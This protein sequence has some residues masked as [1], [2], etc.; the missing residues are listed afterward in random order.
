MYT[1]MLCTKSPKRFKYADSFEG[2]LFDWAGSVEPLPESDF[3]DPLERRPFW[4]AEEST[5]DTCTVD[6]WTWEWEWEWEWPEDPSSF[7]STRSVFSMKK[8]VANP[9]NIPNLGLY[10]SW[11]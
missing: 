6:V 11:I 3:S 1:N 4:E 2:P 9:M 5:P 10:V 7:P 8:N